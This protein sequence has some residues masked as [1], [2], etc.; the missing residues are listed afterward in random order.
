MRSMACSHERKHESTSER[1]QKSKPPTKTV[2]CKVQHMNKACCKEEKHNDIEMLD[3]DVECAETQTANSGAWICLFWHSKSRV[4]LRAFNPP[5][6]ILCF[7]ARGKRTYGVKNF[8]LSLVPVVIMPR[9]ATSTAAAPARRS[10]D[11][12]MAMLADKTC[13]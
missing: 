6:L 8:L 5:P 13:S 3:E 4:E 2:V 11:A 1:I 12:A 10:I 9:R 7:I